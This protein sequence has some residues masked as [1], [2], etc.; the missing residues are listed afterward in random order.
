M[1][2]EVNISPFYAP[3]SGSSSIVKYLSISLFHD[4]RRGLELKIPKCCNSPQTTPH[5]PSAKLHLRHTVNHPFFT[6]RNPIVL[7]RTP[8]GTIQ[9]SGRMKFP[10]L[11][12]T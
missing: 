4:C 3:A 6:Y 8:D 9:L 11:R 1:S 2:T 7:V 12:A 5:R 10:V